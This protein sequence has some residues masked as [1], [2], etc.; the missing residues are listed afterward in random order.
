[1]KRTASLPRH[2]VPWFQ[3]E[4]PAGLVRCVKCKTTFIGK[5]TTDLALARHVSYHIMGKPAMSGG[6]SSSAEGGK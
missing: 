4:Q 3:I 1:M 2:L 5:E 6:G